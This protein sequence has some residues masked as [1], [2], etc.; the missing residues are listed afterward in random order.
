MRRFQLKRFGAYSAIAVAACGATL[1]AVRARAAG[2]PDAGAL[3]YTGYLENPD[4]TPVTSA[5]SIGLTIYDA[6]VDGNAVCAQKTADITPVS[7]RFQITLP[8]KCTAAVKANPDLWVEVE[9]DGAGMGPAKLGAVPYAIEAGHAISADAASGDLLAQITKIESDLGTEHVLRANLN[10]DETIAT[11]T[12]TWISNVKHPSPGGYEL[13]FTA[14]TFSGTPTCVA[15]PNW[16]YPNPPIVAM[17]YPAKTGITLTSSGVD[18]GI[19]LVCAG[20]R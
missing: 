14:G 15:T 12:G 17:Y 1:L 11:K 10:G 5:K 16:P 7:G 9:V 19:F 20:P 2:I 4:G 18:A 8:E 13:T 3:T 6:E